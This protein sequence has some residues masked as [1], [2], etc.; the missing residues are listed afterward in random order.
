[1]SAAESLHPALMHYIINGLGWTSL[2]PLQEKAIESVIAGEDVL[3]LAPTAGGKT[4]AAIFPLLSRM[5]AEDWRGL[6]VLYVCPIKALLNNLEPRLKRHAAALGRTVAV[7]HGDTS[8]GERKTIDRDPPDILLTTPESLEV[9]LVSVRRDHNRILGCLRAIVVDELHA[10]AGDDRG[11]HLLSVIERT[12]KI[13]GRP[14]QRIGLSA[15]IGNPARLLEWLSG[16]AKGSRRVIDGA[17]FERK[18]AEVTLDF[19]GT[20]DNAGS[21]I[22]QLHRGEKR[23]VFVDSRERCEKLAKRLIDLGVRTFVSHSSLGL[24]ER[25]RAEREFSEGKDCVI[26]ATSTLELGIDVG[27]LDRV[28][29][30]DAPFSVASFLQRLGRSGRRPGTTPNFLFLATGDSSFLRGAAIVRLWSEGFVDPVTP[31]V[32]PFHVVA[33]QMVTLALQESGLDRS[34]WRTWLARFIAAAGIDEGTLE[35]IAD[36]LIAEGIIA[37]DGGLLRLGPAGEKIWSGKRYLDLFSVFTSDPLFKVLSGDQEIG[38]VH[39]HSFQVK[40]ETAPILLLGGRS[41][42]VRHIDWARRTVWVEAIAGTGASRWLSGGGMMSFTLCRAMKRVLLDGV[43]PCT[44]TQRAMKKLAEVR[45]K[46][47]FVRADRNALVR[48]KRGRARLSTFAGRAANA[49]LAAALD[50]LVQ[51]SSAVDDLHVP[52]HESVSVDAIEAAFRAIVDTVEAARPPLAPGALEGVKF[53]RCVPENLLVEMLRDRLRD[54][55][56]FDVVCSEPIDVAFESSAAAEPEAPRGVDTVELPGTDPL[57]LGFGDVRSMRALSI[58]QPFA[59]AILRGKKVEEY[60]SAPT[61]IRGRILIY[62]SLGRYDPAQ[63]AALMREFD[64]TD[65]SIEA[66]PRG[67]IVGSVDLYDSDES[68]WRLRLPERAKTPVAPANRANPVWFYPFA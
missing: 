31:P 57:A 19:V 2:R 49:A 28:I 65:T 26:V 35:R 52:I 24:D 38:W 18:K 22:S 54:R 50:G 34:Q 48:D 15:T 1:M 56:A 8:Q 47:D 11:W 21:L 41:W 3:L 51:S 16:S 39:E 58:R 10:F 20:I 46:N 67:V 64:I 68:A 45:A 59:E 9:I 60:R 7:W 33:H 17:G 40:E 63:E 4:E 6:S 42:L 36:H 25:R 12:Q 53:R 14:I 44:L 13:S 23:L 37:E 61:K 5:A 30:L 29:Q 32:T 43:V 62:A 55:S 66:L 27:D